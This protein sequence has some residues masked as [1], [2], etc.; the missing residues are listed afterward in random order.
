MVKGRAVGNLFKLHCGNQLFT[1]FTGPAITGSCS[2]QDFP[3]L[4]KA[5]S[6]PIIAQPMPRHGSAIDF[7]FETLS[8]YRFESTFSCTA[9]YPSGAAVWYGV[10]RMTFEFRI[11][12][13]YSDS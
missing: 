6:S 7:I 5:S 3:T 12:Y 13:S 10:A 11:R 9:G 8:R 2:N 1:T 4:L